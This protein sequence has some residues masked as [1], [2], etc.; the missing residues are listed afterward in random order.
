VQLYVTDV[1]ASVARP[2]RRLVWFSRVTLPAGEARTV[3][4]AVPPTSLAFYDQD[5]RFVCEPGEYV[6]QAGSSSAD[7]TARAA[8]TVG[9][10]PRVYQ[11]RDADVPEASWL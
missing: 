7:N 8:V 1:T 4:F 2:E 5:M 6:F 10:E 11:Q 9:G 3:T